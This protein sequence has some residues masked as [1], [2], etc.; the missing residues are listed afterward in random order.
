[1]SG[2]ET[3]L[4]L[5]RAVHSTAAWQTRDKHCCK[6]NNDVC[7]WNTCVKPIADS[8][9]NSCFYQRDT[10]SQCTYC[11][12]I[13]SYTLH[14]LVASHLIRRLCTCGALKDNC[15]GTKL[16]P[17]CRNAQQCCCYLHMSYELLSGKT[18]TTHRLKQN[19]SRRIPLPSSAPVHN[20]GKSA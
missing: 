2:V 14:P 8:K 6:Q 11:V 9:R 16:V 17:R 4:R 13:P 12:V 15:T 3:G 10:R 19:Y 5:S 7:L 18:S 1:V 20:Y